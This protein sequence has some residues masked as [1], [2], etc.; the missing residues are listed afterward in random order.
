MLVCKFLCPDLAVICQ[1]RSRVPPRLFQS[2]A[3][4]SVI[5]TV[6]QSLWSCALQTLLRMSPLAPLLIMYVFCFSAGCVFLSCCTSV[7]ASVFIYKLWNGPKPGSAYLQADR[8]KLLQLLTG[9][10]LSVTAH[11]GYAKVIHSFAHMVP[12]G[13]TGRLVAR[14]VCGLFH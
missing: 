11:E 5:V 6:K 13:S 2:Q 4:I 10:E 9:Y 1:H 12:H 14:L 8:Q 3:S 7:S